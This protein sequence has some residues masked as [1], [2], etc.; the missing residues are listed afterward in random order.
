M[1]RLTTQPMRVVFYNVRDRINI[2]TEVDLYEACFAMGLECSSS[3]DCGGPSNTRLDLFVYPQ[4]IADAALSAEGA[5]RMGYR[6]MTYVTFTKR[7]IEF[8]SDRVLPEDL[9]AA[10]LRIVPEFTRRRLRL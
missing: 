1:S 5:R 2:L 9:Y 4:N 10:P 7:Y 6:V 3:V 8:V